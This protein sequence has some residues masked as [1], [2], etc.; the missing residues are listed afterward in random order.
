MKKKRS[1]AFKVSK[2]KT[3]VF[4]YFVI[5][6]LI[7]LS[8]FLIYKYFLLEDENYFLKKSLYEKDKKIETL[9][10]ALLDEK[11]RLKEILEKRKEEESFEASEA[12]DYLYSLNFS[13]IKLPPLSKKETHKVTAKNKKKVPKLAIV[14]D[15][16]AFKK[17]IENIKSLP[18]KVT[19]SFFPPNKRHP[20]TPLYAKNFKIYMIHLPLE[21]YKFAR[22]ETNTLDINDSLEKIENRVKEIRAFFPNAKFIN[23]HTGSKFT[24][25]KD[26][27]EK[28]LSVLKKYRFHFLDSKTAPHSKADIVAK[29]LNISILSRDVFLD[30]IGDINYI[31]N[32]LKEAVK[33]AKK[34]GYAVAIGHPRR[35]T[36]AALRDSKEILKDVEIVYINELYKN[37]AF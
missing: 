35:A 28:L 16:I 37:G 22:V 10:K 9:K 36:F 33:I 18:I 31:K 21:A 2:K 14:L 1:H 27:M 11:K 29:E 17:D 23:N 26:A 12:E 20:K 6:L 8:A 13:L 7:I 34:R 32:Q 5:I 19:P 3:S 24:S 25:D 4:P 15:D 30:N